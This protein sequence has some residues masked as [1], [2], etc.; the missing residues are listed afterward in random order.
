MGTLDG[1]VAVITGAA[2]GLG[3]CHALELARRGARV[4]V[5]DLGT[6]AD[7]TG[8]DESAAQAVVDEIKSAGGEATAHFGDAASWDHMQGLVQTAVD[9]YG[10]CNIVIPNAGFIRDAVPWKMTEQDFDDVIRVHLKGHFVLMRHAMAYWR[11]AA[12]ARGGTTYGRIIATSSES[13]L[14][15]NPG[16][17]NY[18]AAKS[19]II[20]LAMGAAQLMQKYGITSNVIMPR[21]RTRMND[22]GP[23]A[24]IFQKPEEGFDNF[25]PENVSPLVAYLAS[26][27]AERV[28]GHVFV[29]WAKEVT[30]VSRPTLDT[31]FS[32]D[33]VW[34]AESLHE[35]LGP[36][37][38]KL[39]PVVDGFT[40]PAM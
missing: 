28:S 29:I 9:T 5:N 8:R 36:H 25:D 33:A 19:G 40:V 15:G 6:V 22:S 32:S 18:S 31:K 37:F 39:E 7:G 16:Q 24:A 34:T 26:P 30:V 21:A 14:F 2:H 12:K 17:P 27:D 35:Q 11:E 1:K 20:A 13:A 38:E 4:V 3:R 23:L 10:D